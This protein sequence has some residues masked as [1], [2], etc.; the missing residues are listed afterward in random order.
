[1]P[2][3]RQDVTRRAG[4]R[5]PP[6]LPRPVEVVIAAGA[7]A[8][9]APVLLLAAAAVAAGSRGGAFFRQTRV[10]RGGRP[11]ELYKLRTMRAGPGPQVTSGDDLR[12]TPVGRLLRKTKLDELPGFW[13][14]VRGDISLVGPRPEV[15]RYVDV[16]D[17][18]WKEVLAVRPGLT[19]PAVL[20]FRHEEDL[21]AS[22][23]GDR[24]VAYIQRVLPEK[25][26]ISRAY[27]A[28]RT[29]RSDL[30]VLFRTLLALFSR[31]GR[32]PRDL[33]ARYRAGE[34]SSSFPNDP[35]FP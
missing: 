29:W 5:F 33:T 35:R 20:A 24:E 25:L 31:P 11:F 15:A 7:L 14:V 1:L 23:D 2:E 27:L 16:E 6:G 28:T 34:N 13:N 32:V 26:R 21:L 4:E 17:P 9:S 22:V 3:V 8:L 12:I 30:R 19:D 18:A 10:G